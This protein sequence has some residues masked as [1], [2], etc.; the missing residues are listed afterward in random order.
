MQKAVILLS[1]G[2][3]SAT[4][5]ALSKQNGF[6]PYALSFRYG[7]RHEFEIDSAGAIAK[8][9]DVKEHVISN[10]D[11]RAFGGSALT[12][13]SID[14]PNKNTTGIPVTYVPARNTIF[15]S[16]MAI[17]F[18]VSYIILLIPR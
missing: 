8:S 13:S 14:V 9:L 4:C 11:L 7:Q 17:I 2:L 1:G 5:I 12:D 15:L 6:E 18:F 16:I 3:D 10:I